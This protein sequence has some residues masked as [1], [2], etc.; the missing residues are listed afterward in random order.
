MN[1]KMIV[2]PFLEWSMLFFR[3]YGCCIVLK[4]MKAMSVFSLNFLKRCYQ[5]S[6]S[7]IFQGEYRS[8]SSHVGSWNVLSNDCYDGTENYLVPL[9]K[10]SSCKVCKKNPL[11]Y[12]HSTILKFCSFFLVFP[13][14]LLYTFDI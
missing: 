14:R 5:C 7:E 9:E 2:S 10:P 1:E 4:E 13:C 6:F 3:M 11:N 8:S 12:F